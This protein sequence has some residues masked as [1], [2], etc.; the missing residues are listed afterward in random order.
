MPQDPEGFRLLKR[1]AEPLQ[2]AAIAALVQFSYGKHGAKT[3]ARWQQEGM[4]LRDAEQ[5]QAEEWQAD[6]DKRDCNAE[7]E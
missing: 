2:Q 5:C 6:D 3:K 4:V 1:A 7:C